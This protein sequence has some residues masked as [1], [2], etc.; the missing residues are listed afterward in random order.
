MIEDVE[1]DPLS[2]RDE[3]LQQL[4][5][6][7]W[8]SLVRFG[9]L[10]TGDPGHAEDLVQQA[11]EKCWPRWSKITGSPE[12]YLEATMAN[13]SVSRWRR[14]RFTEVEL[15]AEHDRATPE[16]ASG[17]AEHD[18]VWRELRALPPRMRAMV[19]LRFV[20]DLSEA[21][22]AKA[23][24]CSVGSVKSQSSRA[25]ARL[26]RTRPSRRRCR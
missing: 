1:G 26:R 11:L 5:D 19:V 17:P 7:R 16:A 14:K 22:T 3:Q 15:G 25:L 4:L 8:N 2:R 9:Y 13:L 23:L 20:E 24:H 21:Q 12:S 18:E 6:T 10:L